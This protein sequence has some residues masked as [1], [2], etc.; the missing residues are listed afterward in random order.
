M[1][2]SLVR[3]NLARVQ[4][5]LVSFQNTKESHFH[6][7]VGTLGAAVDWRSTMS[8]HNK[9]DSP[10]SLMQIDSSNEWSDLEDE[11]PH[12]L[13]RPFSPWTTKQID[14]PLTPEILAMRSHRSS[15]MSYST[16]LHD[17]LSSSDP[18]SVNHFSSLVISVTDLD[19]EGLETEAQE[20]ARGDNMCAQTSSDDKENICPNTSFHNRQSVMTN[21]EYSKPII[22]PRPVVRQRSFHRR[23]SAN[24][25]PSPN[26]L[27]LEEL[28]I[29][30]NGVSINQFLPHCHHKVMNATTGFR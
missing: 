23:D 15:D 9:I 25:L 26:D 5:Q 13:A 11:S 1:T 22:R 10:T 4:R 7:C 24:S 19:L 28:S 29:M 2:L 14:I 21:L 12:L 16:T 6:T 27:K 20:T 8:A 17:P 30:Q 18:S 3:K